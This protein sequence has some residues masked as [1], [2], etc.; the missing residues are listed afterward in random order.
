MR[1]VDANSFY[2]DTTVEV[3]RLINLDHLLA[4]AIEDI[5]PGLPETDLPGLHTVLDL[6]CGPGSWVLDVAF[7]HP[8]CEVAGVDSRQNMIEYAWVRARTQQRFNASF[9]VMDM[10]QPLDF[11]DN[12]FDLI[13]ARFPAGVFH[14]DAW[15]SLI[16]ECMRIL[17]PGGLLY[18]INIDSAI[19]TNSPAFAR[20]TTLLM[21]AKRLAGCYISSHEDAL[22]TS[23]IFPQL[24]HRAGFQHIR[25]ATQFVDVSAEAT[26]W[27]NF[28]RNTEMIYSQAQPLL[29]EAGLVTQEEMNQLYMRVLIELYMQDFEGRWPLFCVWGTK[30]GSSEQ[31]LSTG[32]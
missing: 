16:A 27:A 32:C 7:D 14:G 19:E 21:Q 24:L 9:G 17:C 12:S 23:L 6:G 1:M 28:V 25:C 10:T 5:L 3:A 18:L 29:L 22:D 4:T 13:H 15:I 2:P 30:Q 31:E 26:A 8:E 11:S 20:F